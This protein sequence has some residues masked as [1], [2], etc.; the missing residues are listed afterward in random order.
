VF[1]GDKAGPKGWGVNPDSH[2]TVVL[3]SGGKVVATFGY[4]SVNE[5]DVPKVKEALAKAVKKK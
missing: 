1:P 2:L 4:Q 3:A 5:T